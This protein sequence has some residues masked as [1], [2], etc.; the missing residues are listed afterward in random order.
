MV[1]GE[2][3][4]P[5]ISADGPTLFAAVYISKV[6]P[7]LGTSD[8]E[9]IVS[10]SRL[11]NDA[12]A[13]TGFLV[14]AGR[15]FIQYLEGERSAVREC[16]LRI[17]NDN[18]HYDMRIVA[19]GSLERR[20]FVEWS[21]GYFTGD[22]DGSERLESVLT[23]WAGTDQSLFEEVWRITQAARALPE[24][25]ESHLVAGRFDVLLRRGAS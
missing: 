8:V 12:D 1:P 3:E 19:I 16:L 11:R 20:R 22:K 5:E 18:R 4:R 7:G 21:M 14:R 24:V 10:T 9:S 23:S 25:T 17:A 13:L 2:C 15:N 6:P